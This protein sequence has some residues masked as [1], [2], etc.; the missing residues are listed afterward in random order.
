MRRPLIDNL[1]RCAASAAIII[2]GMNLMPARAAEIAPAMPEAAAPALPTAPAPEIPAAVPAVP[3]TEI[4]AEVPAV[5]APEIPTAVPEVS[6][7][8][9]PDVPAVAPVP[10]APEVPKQHAVPTEDAVPVPS[11][12]VEL[13]LSKSAFIGNS[14]GEGLTMYNAAN[15]NVPLGNATMLTRVCYSFG[16]DAGRNSKFIPKY[17]GVPMQAKEAVKQCGAEYVFI[18]MG[19]NDLVGSAGAENAYEK[20]KQYLTGILAENPTVTIFIES[21]TPSRPGSNV[22]N[23]KITAFNAYMKAYTDLFPNMYYVDIATPMK[24][25]TGYLE[26]SYCSDGSVH[27]TNKA[28]ALWAETVR[29]YIAAFIAAKSEA[30]AKQRS[31]EAAIAKMNY[32]KNIR[33]VDDKKQELFEKRM[34][35]KRDAEAAEEERRR[36][37]LAHVPDEVTLMQTLASEHKEAAPALYN[38]GP[39]LLL[40]VGEKP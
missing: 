20:Y 6:V 34:Q 32:E 5:A 3:A 10:A 24:D 19:T 25:G 29:Q 9:V 31:A 13:F 35:A 12:P 4:P 30:L 16:N 26:S 22:N 2:C 23:E 21:C 39:K 17:G 11:D 37:E 28:Y 33:K 18:C 27:L 15:K 36:Y 38:I 14:V 7:P 40:C 8:P 1:I